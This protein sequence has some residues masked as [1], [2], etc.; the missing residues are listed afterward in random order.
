MRLFHFTLGASALTEAF[1]L[2]QYDV[3]DADQYEDASA[4]ILKLAA[5][6]LPT[7]KLAL[8]K[9]AIDA[10]ARP[11]NDKALE[12]FERCSR[13]ATGAAFQLGVVS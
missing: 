5:G 4:L 9:V 1:I 2:S 11:A 13:A 8:L 3:P 6:Y 12:I 10:L 7:N